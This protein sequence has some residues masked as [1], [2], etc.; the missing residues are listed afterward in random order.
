MSKSK[1]NVVSPDEMVAKYGG[2]SV[3]SYVLLMGPAE[4]DADWNDQGIEGVY[5]FPGRVLRTV[6]DALEE[7]SLSGPAPPTGAKAAAAADAVST[8]AA[9]FDEE[10]LTAAEGSLLVE[11]NQFVVKVTQD[12]GERL[13]F[14]TALAATRVEVR[15]EGQTENDQAH[16]ALV[17]LPAPPGWPQG[18]PSSLN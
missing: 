6:T 11:A 9:R 12:I 8:D 2:D 7:G 14:S 15:P 17:Y 3:R 16:G 5:R 13:R 1:G 4:S 10:S 18:E